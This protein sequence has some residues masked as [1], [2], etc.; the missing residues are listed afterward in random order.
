MKRTIQSIGSILVLVAAMG[1]QC[2]EDREF[3]CKK[4]EGAGWHKVTTW[5]CKNAKVRVLDGKLYLDEKGS[6]EKVEKVYVGAYAYFEYTG[7]SGFKFSVD[8]ADIV[9][10]AGAVG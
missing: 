7:K 3:T 10:L 5:T 1:A 2:S 8:V 6:C 9:G 4:V